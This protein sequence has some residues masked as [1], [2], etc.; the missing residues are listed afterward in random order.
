MQKSGTGRRSDAVVLPLLAAASGAVDALAFIALGHVF[1][2]VMTGNL[3]LM[4]IGFGSGSPGDAAFPLAAL[5]GFSLA[6]RGGGWFCRSEGRRGR[7]IEG[8]PGPSPASRP[9]PGLSPASRPGPGLGPGTGA[10]RSGW[11]LR[12][13]ACLAVEVVLL[14]SVGVVWAAVGGHPDGAGR[15]ALIAVLSVAMGLQ[16]AAMLAAGPAGA[17]TTY[18]TGTLS[19]LLTHP[20]GGGRAGARLAALVAGAVC[21]AALRTWAPA[22]AALPPPLLAVAALS[23]ALPVRPNERLL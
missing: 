21:A 6:V 22:W 7:R 17:P 2:G 16:T 10:A 8:A 4:A 1:A 11:T 20:A 19:S 9:G 3:I 15:G 5:A 14:A 23:L 18:F 13:Y 12:V